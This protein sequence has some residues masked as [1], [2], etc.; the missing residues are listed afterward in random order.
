MGEWASGVVV[1]E[2]ELWICLPAQNNKLIAGAVSRSGSGMYEIAIRAI[3]GSTNGYYLEVRVS[4]SLVGNQRQHQQPNPPY[5]YNL[6]ATYYNSA[7]SQGATHTAT[8]HSHTNNKK[9]SNPSKLAHPDWRIQRR[10]FHF[11]SHQWLY[12]F[13]LIKKKN[14]YCTHSLGLAAPRTGVIIWRTAP[15][16]GAS[17]RCTNKTW[18]K[19]NYK[20]IKWAKNAVLL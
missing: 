12:G 17:S 3:L 4:S 8:T 5:F 18:Y 1:N 16:S 15:K 19:Q 7:H 11:P 20:A 2:L 13:S 10:P 14:I 6:W 9:R